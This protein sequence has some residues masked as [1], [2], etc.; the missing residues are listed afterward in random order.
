[1]LL[2]YL[3]VYTQERCADSLHGYDIFPAACRLDLATGIG[4]ARA[5]APCPY[6]RRAR[7]I[8]APGPP[9]PLTRGGSW[10]SIDREE[11]QGGHEQQIHR[12][13][14]RMPDRADNPRDQEPHRAGVGEPPHR[15]LLPRAR[16][17]LIPDVHLYLLARAARVTSTATHGSPRGATD[18]STVRRPVRDD[19]TVEDVA[20]TPDRGV[21]R[22]RRGAARRP[23]GCD[24]THEDSRSRT[25]PSPASRVGRAR[26]SRRLRQKVVHAG[27]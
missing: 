6:R 12:P 11:D 16:R 5:S 10:R 18:R 1:M 25:A 20:P 22:A 23:R 26:R 24:S 13:R 7:T 15:P 9:S 3:A 8:A 19:V 21:G 17:G 4:W 14:A 27:Q 2:G